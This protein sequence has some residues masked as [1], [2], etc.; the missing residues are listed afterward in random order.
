MLQLMPAVYA[1][2]VCQLATLMLLRSGIVQGTTAGLHGATQL[3][4]NAVKHFITLSSVACG[5][6]FVR[7]SGLALPDA[8]RSYVKLL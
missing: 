7:I 8:R 2:I 6:A 5:A 1:V 4:A 3:V